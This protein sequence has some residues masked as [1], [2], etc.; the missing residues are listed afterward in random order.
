MTGASNWLTALPIKE[1]DE[2]ST[3]ISSK[4]AGHFQDFRRFDLTHMYSRTRRED[5]SHYV[6]MKFVM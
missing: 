3:K 1:L 4:D 5:S 2:L 6:I